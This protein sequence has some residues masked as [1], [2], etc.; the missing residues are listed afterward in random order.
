MGEDGQPLAARITC[1]FNPENKCE[2]VWE[3]QLV[4]RLFPAFT[5]QACET[6]KQARTVLKSKGAAHYWDQVALAASGRTNHVQLKL[7]TSDDSDKDDD[8]ENLFDHKD[9][10]A[11]I[12]MKD[13]S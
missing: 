13:S 6:A 5:F 7:T 4:K 1:Q 9:G 12:V 2:L 8:D 3:G 10:D 11:D